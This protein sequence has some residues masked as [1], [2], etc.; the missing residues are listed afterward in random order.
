MNTLEIIEGLVAVSSKS[1]DTAGSNKIADVVSEL[2]PAS[3][4]LQRLPCSTEGFADDIEITLAGEGRGQ[5]L[6]LGHLDTVFSL[7]E[8]NGWSKDKT[9]LYGSGA[10]DMK[11][12][13]AFIL[14][15]LEKM[16]QRTDSFKQIK[17]LLVFD[18][19]GRCQP[20][21]HSERYKGF[22]ACLVFEE[23]EGD[24]QV[25][26]KRKAAST[27]EVVA[28]GRSS[29]VGSR[30]EEGVSAIR[31]LMQTAVLAESFQKA[32]VFATK[33]EAGEGHNVM[34]GN[35]RMI[36]DYRADNLDDLDELLTKLSGERMGGSVSARALRYWPGMDSEQ[37]AQS[38]LREASLKTGRPI[39]G[40]S[41]GGISDAAWFQNITPVV[42]DGLGPMGGREHSPDEYLEI[43][44]IQERMEIAEAVLEAALER[45][46]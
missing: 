37:S 12:G 35:G 40:S 26:T 20:L 34:P 7:E 16:A 29:H 4:Q 27:I 19:E 13:V 36:M 25:V 10:N 6:L 28:K 39:R 42:I 30:P 3:A 18:E 5:V 31:L 9:K 2:V 14:V 15:L 44:T 22:D 32:Q 46:T 45:A 17:A 1:G 33:I 41:R 43:N 23:G 21:A 11:G 38:V 8:A 24:G